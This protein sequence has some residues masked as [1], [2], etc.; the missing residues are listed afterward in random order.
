MAAGYGLAR[1]V[2][3]AGSLV[4]LSAAGRAVLYA[5]F[6]GAAGAVLAF[7]VV[8]AAIVLAVSPGPR[9][10]YVLSRH[11]GDLRRATVGGGLAALLGM[12]VGLAAIALDT[13]SKG[14][15][16]ARCFVLF[17]T[18]V[19]F[20]GALRMLTLFSVLLKDINADRERT[21]SNTIPGPVS[22]PPGDTSITVRPL[23]SA[24]T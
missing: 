3:G 19:L 4:T 8:P 21:G 10:Q 18:C 9:L 14:N 23:R 1:S 2:F 24:A 17:A 16:S 13:G 12:G 15:L 22:V 7:V 6:M 20:A 5:S 11:P